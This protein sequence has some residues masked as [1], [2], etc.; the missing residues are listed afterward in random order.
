MVV[1]LLA[2]REWLI[3]SFDLW[4]YFSLKRWWISEDCFLPF[5]VKASLSSEKVR[6]SVSVIRPSFWNW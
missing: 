4:M 1:E 2:V 6:F 5:I 3:A